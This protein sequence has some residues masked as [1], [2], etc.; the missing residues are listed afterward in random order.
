MVV[1]NFRV[2][3]GEEE[4]GFLIGGYSSS[5]GLVMCKCRFFRELRDYVVVWG[6]GS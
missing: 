4:R 2:G 3:S 1:W 6:G 5:K